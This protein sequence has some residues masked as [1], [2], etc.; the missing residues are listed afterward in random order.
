VHEDQKNEYGV[1][2]MKKNL[3]HQQENKAEQTFSRT[4]QVRALLPTLVISGV[5]PL[6]IY[7]AMTSIL[8]QPVFLSLLATSIPSLLQS[9]VSIIRNHRLDL[10]AGLILLG[11]VVGLLTT[12]LSRDARFL[13]IRE[14]FFTAAFGLAFLGSLLFPKPLLYY[15]GRSA[16]A[17]GN[18]PARLAL[19]ASRWQQQAVRARMRGM[20]AVVG[21][22]L[23]AEAVVRTFLVF[24][25]PTAQFLAISPF[26]LYGF[27]GALFIILNIYRRRLRSQEETMAEG[28]D[29]K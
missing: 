24:L 12:L 5:L 3:F 7:W 14:S 4:Q 2:H 1:S 11:I 22:G 15:L 27:I 25:L 29:G 17:T 13:L 26:V 19:Y 8:H 9:I 10:L 21:S 18:D 23:L 20:T 6:L 16:A 28:R